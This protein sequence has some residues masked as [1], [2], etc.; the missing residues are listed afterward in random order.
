MGFESF[1]TVPKNK[2]EMPTEDVG[3]SIEDEN[4]E[5]ILY[6]DGSDTTSPEPISNTPYRQETAQT[7]DAE[8]QLEEYRV[9]NEAIDSNIKDIENQLASLHGE[10]ENAPLMNLSKLDELLTEREELLLE[11]VQNTANFPGN[12]TSL[13]Q[14]R[15]LDPI[16]KDR[17][18]EQKTAAMVHMQPGEPGPE[19]VGNK[20]G[21]RYAA[22]YQSQIDNYDEQ[23]AAI[24]NSTNIEIDSSHKHNLGHG[25]IHEP[26]TVYLNAESRKSGPLTIRQKNIIEAHEK[27]HGLRDYQSP[28]EKAEIQSVIDEEALAALIAERNSIQTTGDE[29]FRQSYVTSPEEIIERMAQ[30][31][32]YFGMSATDR[33][34]KE[35]LAHIREHYIS[36]TGLDNGVTDLFRC[37]TTQTETA[38]L[39][40][41][42]KYPI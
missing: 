38:F 11:K 22:H 39:S 7:L 27:G 32:N 24:F 28:I 16:T 8:A 26:G 29:R 9:S 12:W 1:K 31:K 40:V 14:S 3:D 33:F 4:L 19:E 15:M 10:F 25:N 30:F 20:Y 41:I 42:N 34:T 5:N 13:L 17:F 35:H 18:I 21:K 6:G 36:D 37:V 2:S 23:V